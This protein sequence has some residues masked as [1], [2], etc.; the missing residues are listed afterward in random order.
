MQLTE[1]HHT[2]FGGKVIKPQMPHCCHV[3]GGMTAEDLVIV[4]VHAD[5]KHPM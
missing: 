3:C 1:Q 2:E 5:I 4:F